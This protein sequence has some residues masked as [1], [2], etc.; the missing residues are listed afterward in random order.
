M[1]TQILET[2]GL[3]FE[4]IEEFSEDTE[5]GLI[6]GTQPE[7]GEII[8]PDE[9]ITL[10]VSLGIKIEVPEVEGL[11]YQAAIDALEEAGLVATVSGDTN[12]LV[13]SSCLV[14]ENFLSQK[15]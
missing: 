1:P 9:L 4:T 15:G 10:I 12:G 7:A 13:R 11:N 8:T 14:K 6:S 5:E 2:L 3:E